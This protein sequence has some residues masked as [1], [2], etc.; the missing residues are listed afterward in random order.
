M[1]EYKPG[2]VAVATVQ[3]VEGS[4]GGMDDDFRLGIPLCLPTGV[5]E[6]DGDPDHE[7]ERRLDQVPE[8]TADPFHVVGLEAEEAPQGRVGAPL[9]EVPGHLGEGDRLGQPGRR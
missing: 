8:R 4:P 1:T 2:T 9:R 7:H 5:R 6:R 3:G